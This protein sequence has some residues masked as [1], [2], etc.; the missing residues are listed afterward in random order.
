MEECNGNDVA[1][2]VFAIAIT[3]SSKN[4]GSPSKEGFHGTHGT[5]SRSAAVFVCASV[6]MVA[7]LAC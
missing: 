4:E 2:Y 5:P 1:S 3:V 7:T 6:H